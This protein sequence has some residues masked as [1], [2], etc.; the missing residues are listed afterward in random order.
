MALERISLKDGH[1]ATVI[2]GMAGPE[3]GEMWPFR[4]WYSGL[5]HSQSHSDCIFIA[6][7]QVKLFR[8]Q[9]KVGVCDVHT[10]TWSPF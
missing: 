10:R 3:I 5:S 9:D 6:D 1:Q 4:P 8:F 7:A 2:Q